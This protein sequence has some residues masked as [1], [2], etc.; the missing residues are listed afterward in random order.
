MQP[1]R[2]VPQTTGQL[3]RSPPSQHPHTL[4]A[5]LCA[6]QAAEKLKRQVSQELGVPLLPPLPAMSAQQPGG[7]A[8]AG[9][10]AAEA[11]AGGAGMPAADLHPYNVRKSALAYQRYGRQMPEQKRR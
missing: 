7:E 1:G 10:A 4:Q 11:P 3:Q 9:G 8:A 6:L 5:L 2:Q